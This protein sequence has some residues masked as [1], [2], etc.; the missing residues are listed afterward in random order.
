MVNQKTCNIYLEDKEI[1]QVYLNSVFVARLLK[2]DKITT[3]HLFMGMLLDSDSRFAKDMKKDNIDFMKL[4]IDELYDSCLERELKPLILNQNQVLK[5]AV[6]EQTDYSY[7]RYIIMD[8]EVSALLDSCCSDLV[9]LEELT[10]ETSFY[11]H[12]KC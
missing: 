7:D 12:F 9:K 1:G 10:K 11:R 5:E 6:V 3:K 4:Y 2:D 8:D